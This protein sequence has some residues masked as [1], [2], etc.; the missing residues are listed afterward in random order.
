MK[1][2]IITA[3]LYTLITAVLLGIAYPLAITG[4]ARLALP[5]Q[6]SGEL[7]QRNGV[8]I[9][10]RLIG[11]SFTGP[12]YFH[13]RPSNAGNG[14]DASASSGSNLGPTSKALV[15]R[16]TQSVSAETTAEPVPV[17]LVTASGS[18]LDPD[19]SPAAAYYQVG[20]VSGST[21]IPED[22]LRN[23][24]A[25]HITQRQFGLLGEPRVNVLELNLALSALSQK[26]TVP[27]R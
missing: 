8:L 15:Q 22:V 20:R 23:L 27:S 26:K 10:S 16:I 13:S 11:Q 3:C 12:E 18:G 5:A 9:G 25:A 24:V 21:G 2:H 1:R 6:A 17:D 14:Y 7:I 19:I 4:I